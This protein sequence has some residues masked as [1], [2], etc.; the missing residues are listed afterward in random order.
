MKNTNSGGRLTLITYFILWLRFSE[1]YMYLQYFAFS[2]IESFGC[3]LGLKRI[4]EIPINY[5]TNERIDVI[6]TFIDSR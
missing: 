3:Y 1:K 6:A 2:E 4:N 5:F